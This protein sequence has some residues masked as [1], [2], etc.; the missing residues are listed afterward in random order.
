MNDCPRDGVFP[1]DSA[2]N[3]LSLLYFFSHHD[4]CVLF[5]SSKG[6]HAVHYWS[7]YDN[8]IV[9]K[10]RGHSDTVLEVRMSPAD[11]TFLTCSKDGTVRLWDLKQA[12]CVAQLQLP[13]ETEGNPTVA[14]DSTGMVFAVSVPMA[15][16]Q[17]NVSGETSHGR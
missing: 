4:H 9:R 8:K 15:G 5:S 2:C 12:G 17:G 11:D 10:F 3:F 1:H 14:F 7:L 6:Q 16:K 13:G